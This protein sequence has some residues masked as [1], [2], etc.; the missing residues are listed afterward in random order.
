M[1]APEAKQLE[2]SKEVF[3]IT[4]EAELT[5]LKNAVKAMEYHF[6][7]PSSSD[8][9]KKNLFVGHRNYYLQK[10]EKSLYSMELFNKVF[11]TDEYKKVIEES[12][13]QYRDLFPSIHVLS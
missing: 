4:I 10:Y 3:R 2:Q 12:R 8:Y 11:N 13:K 7:Q 6:S 9:P 1:T 5:L